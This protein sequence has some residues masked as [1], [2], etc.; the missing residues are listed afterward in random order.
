MLTRFKEGISN[1]VY[2]NIC[3]DPKTKH[4]STVL[5]YRDEL[6]STK[7]AREESASKR[8]IASFFNKTGYVTTFALENCR[9]VNIAWYKTICLLEFIDEQYDIQQKRVGRIYLFTID[10]STTELSPINALDTTGILDQKWCYHELNGHPALGCVTSDGYVQIYNLINER[11]AYKLKLSNQELV[12][13]DV[14]ALSLDWSTNKYNS[15]NPKIVVSDSSGSVSLWTISQNVLTKTGTWKAHDF[16]AWIAAFDY[17]HPDIFYS[18]GDD[19]VFKCFDSRTPEGVVASNRRY[20][21]GVTALRSHVAIEHQLLTGSYDENIRL[22]DTRNLKAP[23]TEAN[24]NGGV[25]RLKWHPTKNDTILAAC[26]YGGFR[27]LKTANDLESVAEYM[28]H[29][30]I[31]YGADW[32]HDSGKLL[33]TA[34]RHG[35]AVARGACASGWSSI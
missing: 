7:V 34:P 9:T 6:K 27:I 1:L 16:E 33:D 2:S 12:D 32:K 25:W 4:Q 31:A 24:V 10:E 35:A 8:M 23:I 13:E 26:M 17:W 22:W 11:D 14:L 5:V 18:G 15:D 28:D 20:G 21:A 19:S 30:S 29:E 3:H